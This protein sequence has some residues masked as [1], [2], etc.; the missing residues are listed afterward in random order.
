MGDRTLRIRYFNSGTVATETVKESITQADPDISVE[1][2]QEANINLRINTGDMV[3]LEVEHNA[4]VPL[5]IC[6][7]NHTS[8]SGF[9]IT[10]T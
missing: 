7:G 5:T 10:I 9:S 6:T 3:F 4:P 8:V 1:T 2:T